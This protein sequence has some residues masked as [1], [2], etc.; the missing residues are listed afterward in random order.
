MKKL[1]FI[2]LL[3]IPFIGFGQE[4]SQNKKWEDITKSIH[5]D[6][7]QFS[8]EGEWVKDLVYF[9][10]KK[11][12]TLWMITFVEGVRNET[13]TNYTI[14][15]YKNGFIKSIEI[16][17][18]GSS[19][20]DSSYYNIDGL[21]KYPNQERFKLFKKQ[22]E[23]LGSYYHN[24]FKLDSILSKNLNNT[25][26]KHSIIV[27]YD[28]YLNIYYQILKKQLSKENFL[29]LRREQY[30]WLKIR[31]SMINNISEDIQKIDHQILLYKIR[32]NELIKMFDFKF[33][34]PYKYQTWKEG[35]VVKWLYRDIYG[36]ESGHKCFDKNNKEINCN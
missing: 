8:V 7:Y 23:E 35:E 36:N 21:D 15:F 17:Y 20:I 12:K 19:L 14:E 28:K 13:G 16:S 26:L 10:N 3:T 30:D 1:L 4:I 22:H 29:K 25:K 6:I 9:D 2:L 27:E 5:E 31:G 24:M 11:V 32:L 34:Y 18:F 33:N